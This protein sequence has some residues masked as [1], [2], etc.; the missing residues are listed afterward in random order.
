MSVNSI[1]TLSFIRQDLNAYIASNYPRAKLVDDLSA[2]ARLPSGQQYM[3]PSIYK[4][5]IYSRALYWQNIRGVIEDAIGFASSINVVRN[6]QNKNRLDAIIK[7]DLVNQF[8]ILATKIQ[9]L[10]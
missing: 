8:E 1:A 2:G 7:P 6:S 9:F 5:A 3:T 10:L 4:S